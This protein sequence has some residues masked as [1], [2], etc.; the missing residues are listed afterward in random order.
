M[1]VGVII[2]HT[3]YEQIIHWVCIGATFSF[4]HV[5]VPFSHFWFLSQLILNFVAVF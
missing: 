2:L 1:G 4:L 3:K 5:C